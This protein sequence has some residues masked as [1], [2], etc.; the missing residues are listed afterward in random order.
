MYNVDNGIPLCNE[1]HQDFHMIYGYGNNTEEQFL[2]WYNEY[3]D[4]E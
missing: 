4:E 3:L 1:C 2:E